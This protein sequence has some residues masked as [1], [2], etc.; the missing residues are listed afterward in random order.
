MLGMGAPCDLICELSYPWHWLF[1]PS[2]ARPAGGATLQLDQMP[3]T[4]Q[5]LYLKIFENLT[6][7]LQ[8]WMHMAINMLTLWLWE[9][10]EP[11][12]T[13]STSFLLLGIGYSP[14]S[15]ARRAGG[16]TL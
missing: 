2:A 4:C 5:K 10:W 9:V 6:S 1:P 8:I 12:V 15:A 7:H 13:S 14:P 3:K 11:L 16:A